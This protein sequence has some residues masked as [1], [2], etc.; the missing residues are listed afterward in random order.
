MPPRSLRPRE[1]HCRGRR[2]RQADREAPMT[3][4]ELRTAPAVMVESG[5]GVSVRE[6]S[7]AD[8][9]HWDELVR[10]FSNHRVVHTRAWVESLEAA[11][12]GRSLYFVFEKDGEVVGCLPGLLA[13]VAGLRLFGS[14]LPGWQTVSMG[15]A[16]DPA[17][18][19][20]AELLG[21][22]LPVLEGKHR[23]SYI[24]LL[25]NDLD[26]EVMRSL[27]F[28][29]R[30]VFTYRAPLTPGN[31]ER[32]LRAMKDTVRRNV[33]RAER[34]GLVVRFEEDQAFVVEHYRQLREVYVRGGQEIPFSER[35]MQECFS[36]MK[37]AGNLLAV[38]VYLP[39][40]RVSIASGIFLIEG[41]ELLLW[42][43]AHHARYRWYRPTELMTWRV[44]QRAMA[45]G[46]ETFD[47]MGRG[48]F[49][50][51]FAA[52]CAAAR[53]G[54]PG[55]GGWLSSP[56]GA[57]SRCGG[58][59]CAWWARASPPRPAGG[60]ATRGRSPASWAIW[61]WC[62]RSPWRGSA[63]SWWRLP[64]R[65]PDSPAPPARSST[66]WTRGSGPTTSWR[67]CWSTGRRNPSRRCCSTRTTARCCCSPATASAWARRSG[68]SFP[69]PGWWRT[70]WTR[71]ASSSWRPG[72]NSRSR[73]RGCSSR[74][75][76]PA[77]PAS[78]SSRR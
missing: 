49:K 4:S 15:P 66:G 43:W 62:G 26:P 76:S 75:G 34:L 53:A 35:R 33:R 23:V 37:A 46:C 69:T 73:P 39:G 36:R 78:A 7:A 52:G 63:A 16:F 24:E 61:T 9:E 19:S 44:M 1:P 6:A 60:P 2:W 11:G 18:L 3:S 10:R 27:G 21:A 59:R 67:L 28:R 30:P 5:T 40:G 22:L 17:R 47:L 77:L 29:G 32:M 14:P 72:S 48:K 68:S 57:S 20:T 55:P 74:P 13:T 70:W 41:R 42:S 71:A 31:E 8:L 50:T 12:L 58:T 56:T 38:A 54:S 65:P 64:A 51:K 45:A 25:H